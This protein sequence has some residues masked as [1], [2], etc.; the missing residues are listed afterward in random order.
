MELGQ[1]FAKMLDELDEDIVDDAEAIDLLRAKFAV[2][3]ADWRIESGYGLRPP[4]AGPKA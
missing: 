4:G 3:F 2:A 1:W